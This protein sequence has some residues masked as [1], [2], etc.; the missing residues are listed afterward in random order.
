MEQNSK[1]KFL[2]GEKTVYLR[3]INYLQ[4]IGLFIMG[5]INLS[6]EQI[7]VGVIYMVVG[8]VSFFFIKGF[9]DIIDL[10]DS[11]N[12]KIN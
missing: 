8:V 1:S 3:F 6:N 2:Y 7:T 11:I 4:L 9:S 10:L 12:N 5:M